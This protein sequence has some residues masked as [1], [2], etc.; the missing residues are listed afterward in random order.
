M[1]DQEMSPLFP[2]AFGV[3]RL[4][5]ADLMVIT[6]AASRIF[7][8]RRVSCWP[9]SPTMLILDLPVYQRQQPT[10][11]DVGHAFAVRYMVE[12]VAQIGPDSQ[13]IDLP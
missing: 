3:A 12:H 13:F 9:A 11:S 5:G 10:V 8:D 6:R 7:T 1:A 2:V 4:K